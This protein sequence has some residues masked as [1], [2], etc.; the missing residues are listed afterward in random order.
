MEQCQ[1]NEI[2][3]LAEPNRHRSLD[4]STERAGGSPSTDCA[5]LRRA[6]RLPANPLPLDATSPTANAS[7]SYEEKGNSLQNETLHYYTK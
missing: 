4:I 5:A 6:V 3:M 2:E 7:L 1:L